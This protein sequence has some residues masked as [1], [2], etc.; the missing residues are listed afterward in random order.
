MHFITLSTLPYN[1][2]EISDIKCIMLKVEHDI[3]SYIFVN[4]QV[5]CLLKLYTLRGFQQAFNNLI[6]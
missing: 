1:K 6:D 4:K 2:K 3:I 5:W